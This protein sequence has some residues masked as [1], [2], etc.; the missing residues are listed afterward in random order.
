MHKVR[1]RTVGLTRYL[2]STS[3]PGGRGGLRLQLVPLERALFLLELGSETRGVLEAGEV[4]V[5]RL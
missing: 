5:A 4:D 3:A 2:R 1:G